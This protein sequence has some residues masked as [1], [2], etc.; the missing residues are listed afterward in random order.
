MAEAEVIDPGEQEEETPE[1][2][3]DKMQR[4]QAELVN[5]Q[6]RYRRQIEEARE[7]GETSVAV[8]FLPVIDD[9]HRMMTTLSAK[10]TKKTDIVEAIQ[11]I[12]NKFCKT[13]EDLAIHGFQ[14]EG[15]QFTCELME[16]IGMEPSRSLPPGT[17]VAE[18]EQGYMRQGRLLRPAKVTVA[19]E[20]AED[21]A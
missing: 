4:A 19:R 15:Q 13:L 14:S 11:L 12:F 3:R 20:F 9:F 5:M 2:L 1:V 8:A 17:V 21:D 16:A 18:L 10:R 6:D 7:R